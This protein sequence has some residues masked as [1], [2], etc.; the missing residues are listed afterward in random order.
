MSRRSPVFLFLLF[1]ALA[2]PPI[3]LQAQA[4]IPETSHVIDNAS[5]AVRKDILA[6]VEVWKQAVI[7]KDRQAF[8]RIL[9]ED[10]SYGHTTGEVLDKKQTIDRY[11]ASPGS[12]TGIDIE[13]LSIRVYGKYALLTNTATFHIVQDGKETQATLSGLDVWVNS[14]HGWQLLARQL[15]RPVAH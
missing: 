14:G 10:L 4:P 15:T 11:L 1:A 3:C 12:Y 9:N 7:H 8:E 13:G 6:A 5:P 2:I